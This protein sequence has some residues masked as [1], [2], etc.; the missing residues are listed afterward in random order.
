MLLS[1]AGFAAHIGH[2]YIER[3]GRKVSLF[4]F[5][6]EET[7]GLEVLI[8]RRWLLSIGRSIQ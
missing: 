3:N 1:F 4:E 2:D 6:R 7:G 8:L 5:R